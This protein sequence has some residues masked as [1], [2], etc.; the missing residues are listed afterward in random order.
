M[1][2]VTTDI[3]DHELIPTQKTFFIYDHNSALWGWTLLVLFDRTSNVYRVLA[4]PRPELQV[5]FD[6]MPSDGD[7]EFE[8]PEP[9]QFAKNVHLTTIR[10]RVK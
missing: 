8:S 7:H 6:Q 4:F 9:I 2:I 3:S 10:Y 1:K 5:E